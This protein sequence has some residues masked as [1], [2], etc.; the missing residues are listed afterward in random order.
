MS[1]EL[2]RDAPGTARPRAR[3]NQRQDETADEAP[4][5]SQNGKHARR[6]DGKV[7]LITGGGSGVGAAS[8]RRMAAEGAAVA[9]WGRT[10]ETL[11][12]VAGD[13]T[14][15]GGRALAV[16]CDVAAAEQVTSAMEQTMATFGRLDIV[17]AN[18]A[19]QLHGQDKP[20]HELSDEIWDRTHDVN[21]RGAFFTCR[22]GIAHLLR[23]GR[24]GAVIIVS[25][26]TALGGLAP[27]NPAY[28]ATKGG[29]LA[30]GRAMAVQYAPDGIRVNVVCPGALEAPPDVE[31]LG[32]AGPAAR[33]TRLLPQ[34]PMQRLGRFAEIAPMIA[35]LA[36]EDASY[37]TGGVFVV[38]GGLTAR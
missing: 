38:D 2:L 1:R 36:S 24:G 25:S 18:A 26:V 37:V 17:V 10:A 8:A 21:L 33:E 9:L 5:E 4:G 6:L 12:A 34:I 32:A 15:S 19:I 16:P 7:A 31:L 11:Q 22:A 27:Q 13:V 14:R 29:L 28:T 23:Q 30:L 3:Q 20:V 35:F